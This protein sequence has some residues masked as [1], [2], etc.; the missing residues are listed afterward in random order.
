M[1]TTYH[2]LIIIQI[3]AL[4]IG[5]YGTYCLFCAMLRP[6]AKFLLGACVCAVAYGLGYL[7]ELVATNQD[8]AFDA[9]CMQ[10][11]GLTYVAFLFS[12]YL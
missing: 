11:C 1:V 9:L 7:M 8:M 2:V 6:E 10:Y 5:L 12:I 4:A 3:I